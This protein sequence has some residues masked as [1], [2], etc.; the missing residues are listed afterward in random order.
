MADDQGVKEGEGQTQPVAAPTTEEKM[1]AEPEVK[2]QSPETESTDELGLPKDASERTRQR[3]QELLEENKQLKE[4]Q[5]QVSEPVYERPIAPLPVGGVPAKT[6]EYGN[7]NPAYV[8][9][10]EQRQLATE[11]A[12]IQ[13][14]VRSEAREAENAYPEIKTDSELLNMARA[15]KTDSLVYPENYKQA[16]ELSLKEALDFVKSKIGKTVKPNVPEVT[17]EKE[18]ASLSAEG[19]PSQGVQRE[20]SDE[21]FDSVR[22]ETARGSKDAMIARM[23]NIP[24]VNSKG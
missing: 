21:E 24:A 19:R 15:V 17:P 2:E 4:A 22:W 3:V 8:D 10:I 14:S 11:Q 23:K 5:I 16:R 6:D 20:L 13:G 12:V 1:P 9:Y 18:Q 7:V